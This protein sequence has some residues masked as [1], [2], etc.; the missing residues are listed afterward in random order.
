[1][2]LSLFEP[3]KMSTPTDSISLSI[4][5]ND[6]SSIIQLLEVLMKNR[7]PLPT[8]RN[9]WTALHYAASKPQYKEYLELLLEYSDSILMDI[10]GQT[11]HEGETPLHIA[12]KNG[13]EESVLIL[14]Q[15][16]CDPYKVT[17]DYRQSA[18]HIA[19]FNGYSKIIEYLLD[20]P[21]NIN[22]PAMMGETP[23]HQAASGK[24]NLEVG[25]ILLARGVDVGLRAKGGDSPLHL[26]G[27]NNNLD[28]VGAHPARVHSS[29]V[30][31]FPDFLLRRPRSHPRQQ[32]QRWM[33]CSRSAAL[34][35]VP[36]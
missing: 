26:A 20:Y 1:M 9:N 31:A 23:L 28:I 12:C 33:T 15:K 35:V 7:L 32:L 4:Q 36:L 34:G 24:S 25:S 22:E 16:G 2:D 18:L 8:G 30:P 29:H 5:R 21:E 27:L 6:R 10:N 14:L 13:C 19:A 3:S 17:S 11:E